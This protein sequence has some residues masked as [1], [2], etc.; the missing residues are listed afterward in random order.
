VEVCGTANVAANETRRAMPRPSTPPCQKAL[1]AVRSVKGDADEEHHDGEEED[2]G[3]KLHGY[4]L[5][6]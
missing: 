2:A 4:I 1:L 5:P 3:E 6:I